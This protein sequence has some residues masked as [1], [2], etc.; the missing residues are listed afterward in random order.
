MDGL[1]K[2]FERKLCV[3]AVLV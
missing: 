1:L 2:R 3:L